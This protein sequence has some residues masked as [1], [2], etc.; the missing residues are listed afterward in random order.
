MDFSWLVF[1]GFG[2]VLLLGARPIAKGTINSVDR[3]LHYTP[4][5][6]AKRIAVQSTGNQLGG[7]VCIVL[8]T[9]GLFRPTFLN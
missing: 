5:K 2:L 1:I 3:Y 8:G 4:E 6:K 9:I 7:I